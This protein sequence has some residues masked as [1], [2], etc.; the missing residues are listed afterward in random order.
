MPI[1]IKAG[2]IIPMGPPIQYVGEKPA[3]PVTLYVYA[4]A[5]GEFTLYED[6]GVNYN[7]EN[8]AY[9]KIP[10]NYHDSS[11]TV[12]IG[13]RQ[14]SFQGM[15]QERIFHVVFMRKDDPKPLDFSTRP[16]H[17]VTYNGAELK[18]GL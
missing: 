12:V 7:Y 4:G 16:D 3:G 2:S 5:D 18:I 10:I 6:E 14:G 11:K 15:V 13:S 9:S 17:T 8:G 1:Y